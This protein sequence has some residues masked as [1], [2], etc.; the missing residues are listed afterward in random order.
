MTYKF[1][2]EKL[3]KYFEKK[4]NS[5]IEKVTIEVNMNR[6]YQTSVWVRAY[7]KC[8][9]LT[10]DCPATRSEAAYSWT[11]SP[12]S[13]VFEEIVSLFPS[14]YT[15]ENYLEWKG[16]KV[17]EFYLSTTSPQWTMTLFEEYKCVNHPSEENEIQWEKKR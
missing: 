14:G 9:G 15:V 1:L 2:K 17:Q 7:G 6:P 13:K 5:K 11:M 3:T 8:P 10:A 4:T 16:R 12:Q